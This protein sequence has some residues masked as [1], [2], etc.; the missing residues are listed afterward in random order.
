MSFLNNNVSLLKKKIIYLNQNHT[1][2]KFWMVV[3]F[4]NTFH[5]L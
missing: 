3:Y 4:E 1:E 2:P 5:K